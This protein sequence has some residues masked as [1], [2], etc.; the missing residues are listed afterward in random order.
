MLYSW[1]HF[2]VFRFF[3]TREVWCFW[4]HCINSTSYSQY[5]LY[6]LGSWFNCHVFS[7]WASKF[8]FLCDR[9]I[10]KKVWIFHGS[11][12][13]IFDL[14]CISLWHIIV[15]VRPGNYRYLS[16]SFL[17]MLLLNSVLSSYFVNVRIGYYLD[18]QTS[19]VVILILRG[20]RNQ[21]IYRLVE[22]LYV[23]VY[24]GR[25]IYIFPH[26]PGAVSRSPTCE[27]WGTSSYGDSPW[28]NSTPYDERGVS[29]A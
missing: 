9:S 11:R 7:Y 6:D 28:S 14:R 22:T 13:E 12:L 24:L 29:V 1:Y 19:L 27:I 25:S 10:K 8:M 15:W 23:V 5:A 16:L 21:R 26:S 17:R 18:L 4:I 2:D 3:R 20:E